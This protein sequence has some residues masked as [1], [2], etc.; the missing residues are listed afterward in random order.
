MSLPAGRPLATPKRLL[1]VM[2]TWLGDCVMATP[3]LRAL[4]EALP[5]TR[6]TALVGKGPR[7]MLEATPWLDRVITIRQ[8]S[9]GYRSHRK[10]DGL[11]RIAAR[12]KAGRFDAALL[13]R[14]SF[15]SA[16]LVALAG[17]PCRVG[18]AR[19][20]RAW[21]LTHTLLPPREGNQLQPISAVDYYLALARL[22]GV[23]ESDKRLEL[24][25][26]SHAEAKAD[27]ILGKLDLKTRSNRR[28]VLLNPGANKFA[29][30][31]PADRFASLADQ[32]AK[33]CDADIAVTGAPN[34]RE[35]LDAV[36]RVASSPIA[37]LSRQGIGLSELK[38][39]IARSD[40]LVTND[41]GPRHIGVAMDVPTVT[42]FGTTRP[43][44]TTLYGPGPERLV[45]AEGAGQPGVT[46]EAIGVERVLHDCE[47]LLEQ[48]KA[49]GENTAGREGV[50]A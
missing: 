30:R 3:T 27:A 31:W 29:K 13:L 17:I 6:I 50:V 28:L 33:R 23:F 38:A 24:F 32:L 36:C 2:P 10:P 25:T 49:L 41:T 26:R 16:L 39:I 21:L 15:K 4:R 12:L 11:L 22:F 42:L 19:D 37:D 9:N 46:M 7:P 20:G 40:L 14:N 18:Y 35:V 47:V 48:Q 34:E 8:G 45:A 44:W 5:D 43:D 1:V